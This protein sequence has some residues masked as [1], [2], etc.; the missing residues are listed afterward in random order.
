[1]PWSEWQPGDVAPVSN[2]EPSRFMKVATVVTSG[3]PADPALVQQVYDQA[4]ADVINAPRGDFGEDSPRAGWSVGAAADSTVS[5]VYEGIYRQAGWAYDFTAAWANREAIP[6]SMGTLEEL[7]DYDEIPGRPGEYVEYDESV[8]VAWMP[9]GR[10]SV[11]VESMLLEIDDSALPYSETYEV[12]LG[13]TPLASMVITSSSTTGSTAS[14]TLLVE[15]LGAA[16]GSDL[17]IDLLTQLA[18][19]GYDGSQ[20]VNQ[21]GGSGARFFFAVNLA[22]RPNLRYPPYRYW[23]PGEE[24]PVIYPLRMRQRTDGLGISA[25]RQFSRGR[26]SKQLS[27]R[28]GWMGTHL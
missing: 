26:S 18:S 17:Q 1:M 13:A 3:T 19:G 14:V 21:N 2:A 11:A 4:A 12:R 28:S 23:I 6:A 15:D 10:F 24:E 8:P 7:V 27:T 5:W 22:F 20:L 16:V 25:P 9:G